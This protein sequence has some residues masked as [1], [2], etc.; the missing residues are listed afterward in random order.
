M[1]VEAAGRVVRAADFVLALPLMEQDFWKCAFVGSPC[2]VSV[3][4]SCLAR[5]PLPVLRNGW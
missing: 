1:A 3:L 5:Y 2:L 4:C